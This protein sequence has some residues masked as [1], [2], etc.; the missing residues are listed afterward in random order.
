M[1]IEE[2]VRNGFT[3]SVEDVA[4]YL[5]ESQR[6]IRYWAFTGR[7]RAVRLGRKPWRFRLQDVDAFSVEALGFS[8]A[9]TITA[10]MEGGS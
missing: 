3:M 8:P 9:L 1:S 6:N 4:D 5:G 10:Q 2:C 7:L